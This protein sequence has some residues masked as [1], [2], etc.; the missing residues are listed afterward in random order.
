M[1]E[2]RY[3]LGQIGMCL[4]TA[5]LFF[6]TWKS[7]FILVPITGIRLYREREVFR[8]RRSRRLEEHFRDALQCLLAA[9]EAGY[10][11]ENSII[12]AAEDLRRMLDS[13][14]PIT[15]EFLRMSRRMQSGC[16]AEEVFEDFGERSGVPD[17]RTFSGIFSIAKRSGGDVVRVI[18]AMTDT[19]YEKQEVYREIQTVLLAKQ[20]EVGI[21]K[22][23]PYLMLSYFL[24]FSPGFLAPLY[25]GI[26]GHA[27]M[28]VLYLLYR[29]CCIAAER[30]ALIEI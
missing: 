4:L 16:T 29:G 12:H 23:M 21:M 27:I 17:I 2:V 13:G 28:L 9:M 5:F 11:V 1:K 7:L 15:E 6:R 3:V 19:L 30:M 24:L 26:T 25:A 22:A 18:R 10:S 20:F 8:N 14:E